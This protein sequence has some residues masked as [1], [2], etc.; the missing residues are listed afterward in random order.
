MTPSDRPAKLIDA[1]RNPACYDHPVETV[2]LIE[3]HISYVLLAGD[4]AYKLKKPVDL[5][6]LDFS[7]LD[8]RRFYCQEELRLNRRLAPDIY[9][10][11][12][13]VAG[14]ADAP[15]VGGS[16]PVLEWAVKMRRFPQQAL[17]SQVLKQGGLAAAHI[18]AIAR[19]VADFHGRAAIAGRASPFGEAERVHQ[20]VL[21]NFEQIRTKLQQPEDIER[22]EALAAW[23]EAQYA[24]HRDDFAARKRGG[25]VR[26]CH[27]DMHLGNMVLMDG[28]VTLFDCI[29]FND[30]LRWI[31]V[32]SEAAFLAM[33]LED[34][35]RPDFARRFLN[36][37]LEL[38][39]DYD[40]L[41]ILRYYLAYRALVRAKVAAIR[42][43]QADAREGGQAWAEY[44]GHIE[45]AE[46]L[47]RP[48]RPRLLITHGLSGCG[49]TTITQ[50]LLAV[51]GAIRLRSDVERKRL[52]GL[53]PD[54]RS[55]SGVEA[56]LY[57]AEAGRRTY[58]RLAE[59][60]DSVIRAGYPV[61]VD[62]TFLKRAQREQFR[63]LAARRRVPFAILD[64]RAKEK[65]LRE[66][67]AKREQAGADASEAGLAVLEHQLANREPLARDE[68]PRIIVDSEQP[69]DTAWLLD[70]W[71]RIG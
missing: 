12:V 35:K 22:L 26:E 8:K 61:I 53:A 34:R 36:G 65:T 19:Q 48:V 28:K 54:A 66:R 18:D 60:A 10:D 67:V 45:L 9:L 49:K 52:F 56:G 47:T 1:L 14:T 4:F 37:Y 58:E 62:A 43:G 50:S 6:F 11:L 57:T 31:D 27:G 30:N 20:P 2:E 32:M 70:E 46:R 33:D 21:Q 24:A 44:R 38:T 29:E 13:P 25:F 55:G 39:G 7:T 69:L 5:G 40:G 16:G 51:S 63:E 23:S 64:C 3:T 59:L 15:V 41:V 17:L 42:A 71:A 68:Q